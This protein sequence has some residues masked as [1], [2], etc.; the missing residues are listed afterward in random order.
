M[1][2]ELPF[3]GAGFGSFFLAIMILVFTVL[4]GVIEAMSPEAVTALIGALAGYIF[5]FSKNDSQSN[6]PKKP[7]G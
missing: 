7:A 4:M 2:F 3:V 6:A 5:G 1:D